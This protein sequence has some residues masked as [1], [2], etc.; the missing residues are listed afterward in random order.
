MPEGQI[1]LE[2]EEEK[3]LDVQHPNTP[4]E[5]EEI[6]RITTFLQ[7]MYDNQN[8]TWREF[9]DRTFKQYVD[10]N[11]KRIN[12]YVTPRDEEFDDWQTKGFEGI[13]RE[14][15]FAFVSKIAMERPSFKY[16]AINKEGFIDKTVAEIVDDFSED[17]HEKE[18]PIG[19]GFFSDA[20]ASA[21][22]GGVIKYEGIEQ[23]EII[24]EDFESYDFKTGKITGLKEK[25]I[26]GEIQARGRRVRPLDFL[27]WDWYQPDIQKQP[28]I[29]EVEYMNR[30]EFDQE[31][32]EYHLADQVP[33]LSTVK[34]SYEESFYLEQWDDIGVQD[35]VH[36]TRFYEKVNGRTRFR[37]LANGVLILATPIPRK[38][39]KYPYEVGIFKPFADKTFIWGKAL[40]D[41]IAWDQD[42]YNAFKNMVVD[43]AILHVQRPLIT[44]G[45]NEITD[46]LISPNK[47]L[48]LQGNVRELDIAAPSNADMNILAELRGSMDR[49]TTDASQS[50]QTQK[51]V[52]AREIV[53]A[54]ENAKKLAGVGRMFLE[55][56]ALRCE[57]LRV[58]TILQFYFEPTRIEGALEK[59]D[60]EMV[61]RSIVLSGK[62]LP[63]GV[64]GS[65]QIKL[66]GSAEDVPPVE[67]L[68]LDMVEA[69]VLGTDIH[70]VVAN[71]EYIRRFAIEVNII[72]ESSFESSKSME[73]ALESEY[74]KTIAELFPEKFQQFQD[75]FFRSIN[76]IYEKDMSE[77]EGEAQQPP[78]QLPPGT[79]PEA[80]GGPP[81]GQT[82]VGNEL[83]KPPSLAKLAGV[84]F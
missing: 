12:N 50:G 82:P 79:P 17:S 54:N 25:H 63:D 53:I 69:K 14:K 83:A 49:Q 67:D 48:N 66:V 78:P 34:D 21:G 6:T 33:E 56:F 61:Y 60:F 38:D 62:K 72:P 44:D 55:D 77:F 4:E 5:Q 42:I 26:E 80:A 76:D 30:F 81:A 36:V 22:H 1:I 64:T 16:K 37:I 3:V 39:R 29:A 35:L 32:G 73:L 65:K 84:D 8:R 23:D 9:N 51:G 27:W 11:E 18:D 20:W 40:P 2:K 7:Q 24:E 28:R 59:D 74:M 15:M 71:T 13:T 52:T 31:F 47:V 41:E 57:R 68:D 45:V 75:V 46:L 58:G 43:R 10:D 70:K 19:T